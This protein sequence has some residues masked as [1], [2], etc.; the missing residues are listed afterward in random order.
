[1]I[2]LHAD[3]FDAESDEEPP[4]LTDS[5]NSQVSGF[6]SE[7]HD[8]L[9]KRKVRAP[10]SESPLPSSRQHQRRVDC[11]EETGKII[12]TVLCCKKL[13]A[14]SIMSIACL[15]LSLGLNLNFSW[16]CFSI[17]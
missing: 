1:M 12:R 3:D 17:N 10:L 13:D 8:Y 14:H 7:I 6:D 4:E 5:D 11:L 2:D 15:V 16:V 9:L